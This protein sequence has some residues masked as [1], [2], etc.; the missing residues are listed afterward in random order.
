VTRRILLY[1]P[2]VV[3]HP[4][5]YCRVIDD[6]LASHDCERVVAMG[7]TD[8][9]GLAQSPDLHPLVTRERV[10]II[11]NRTRSAA[12]RPHLTA[13]EL[14][15]LQQD[16]AIDTTLFIEADKSNDELRRIAAGDAPRL[17]GRNLGI[18]ANTAEWYPGEDSFT[19]AP[20]RMIAPTVRTTLGNVKRAIF[21]RRKTARWFYE[22][23]ILGAQVLDEILTKDERLAEWYGP[24]VHWMPEI[25]RPAD[26]EETDADR[27][28]YAQTKSDLDR[29]LA[30]NAGR[31][32]VLYFG[33]AAF[34]KGYD[35]FLAFVA[36]TPGACAIHPGRTFDAVNAGWFEHDVEAL[37]ARL[38]SEGRL[39]ETNRY[40]HAHRLKDLFFGAIRLYITTHRLALSSATVI[41]AVE[42]GK[43]VLVPD[44]GLLGYRVRTNGIGDVYRYGDLDELQRKAEQLWRS[45][46]SRFEEPARRFWSR[47]SDEAIR[48]FFVER[49]LWAG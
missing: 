17:H 5:V 49:L 15:A 21:E 35:L 18:F 40:V 8:E 33:D 32:P 13:E 19:G 43:P 7:F 46:L 22:R 16:L 3:G 14:V 44:R 2:D 6:A 12:G 29:F 1:S 38:R 39:F 10:Q 41:Q 45:D 9:T 24:P 27:A 31:E 48:D 11:D 28:E 26:A 23:V 47:F 25:S 4:R 42:L 34:Y 20:K 36:R 37:R 30:A